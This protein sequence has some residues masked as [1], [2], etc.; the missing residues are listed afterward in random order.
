MAKLEVRRRLQ[1]ITVQIAVPNFLVHSSPN[2]RRC[3]RASGERPHIFHRSRLPALA[4][5]LERLGTLQPPIAVLCRP[6]AR[7]GDAQARRPGIERRELDA[8]TL[9]IRLAPVEYRT[10]NPE[11][12][13]YQPRG[14]HSEADVSRIL[15]MMRQWRHRQLRRVSAMHKG[16]WAKRWLPRRRAVERPGNR[17]AESPGAVERKLVKHVVRM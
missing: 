10:F 15:P 17:P 6:I 12:V 8:V 5:G 11:P 4:A 7:W 14:D 9:L 16:Y 2:H 3:P 1:Q 13:H